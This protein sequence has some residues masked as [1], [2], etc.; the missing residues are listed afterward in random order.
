M[1]G[2]SPRSRRRS[3][4]TIGGWIT[5]TLT[6][7]GCSSSTSFPGIVISILVPMLVKI[8]KPDLS[9][10]KG[11]DYLG[12][13]LMAMFLGC[14]EYVLEEGPRWDWFDDATIRDCAWVAVVAGVLFV[15]RSLTF[16]QPGGRSARAGQ[17]QLR[18]RLLLLV[19]HRHRHLRDDLPDAAVPRLRARLQ[20]LADRRRGVLDRHGL[21]RR[22]PGLFMLREADSTC[23]G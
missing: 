12:M 14:L 4:P 20:R 6:G 1:I 13:V 8:D 3:G 10:L 23:A 5:D 17:P 15:V 16:A 18:A 22:R 19:R 21:A 2:A 7:T 9:L 11:A